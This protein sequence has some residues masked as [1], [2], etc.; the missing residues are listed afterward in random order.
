MEEN[1]HQNGFK[2]WSP[3]TSNDT[4][5]IFMLTII[6]EIFLNEWR[7]VTWNDTFV[8]FMLTTISEAFRKMQQMSLWNSKHRVII[9]PFVSFRSITLFT[10]P[11]KNPRSSGYSLLLECWFGMFWEAF[12]PL[13]EEFVIYK[14]TIWYHRKCTF[15]SIFEE[16]RLRSLSGKNYGRCYKETKRVQAA[17]HCD[18]L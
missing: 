14:S 17:N 11:Q 2:E 7:P 8:V 5:A 15:R 1:P 3:V 13:N 16:L 18:R 12:Q 10:W 4:F 9:H 6:L